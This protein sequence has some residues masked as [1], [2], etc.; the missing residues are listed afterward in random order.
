MNPFPSAHENRV[1]P[2][3]TRIHPNAGAGPARKIDKDY[4]PLVEIIPEPA[5]GGHWL[6][7]HTDHENGAT[8]YGAKFV[9]YGESIELACSR[10]LSSH[11]C[12]STP[13]PILGDPRRTIS[14]YTAA[15]HL[16]R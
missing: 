16:A 6:Y 1:L 2:S 4:F 14:V 5:L 3:H 15:D 8:D 7:L 12:R 10:I 11:Y 9:P 13:P